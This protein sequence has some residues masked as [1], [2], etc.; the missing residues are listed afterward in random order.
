MTMVASN[1]WRYLAPLA[2]AAATG[3]TIVVVSSSL[4]GS[5]HAGTTTS[6]ITR[7]SG[8]RAPRRHAAHRSYVVRAGDTLSR[9]AV[10]TGVPVATI[11][12]LNPGVDPAAL[13]T[14]Q[15]LKLGQ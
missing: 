10:E 13:Q 5:H 1:R 8:R 3:A 4:G 9:I 15:R 2:L 14:G 6:S 12:A 7:A 11:E